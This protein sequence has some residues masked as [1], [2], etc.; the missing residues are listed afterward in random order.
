[1]VSTDLIEVGV[2]VFFLS[3]LQILQ[4][5][6]RR[7]GGRGRES[8]AEGAVLSQRLPHHHLVSFHVPPNHFTSINLSCHSA[9]SELEQPARP[10]L[11]GRARPPFP[12]Q[13][14]PAR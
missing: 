4:P 10:T 3:S 12:A 1:M 2:Y 11:Q 5:H 7:Q 8:T 14:G 9:K 6:Q 13:P